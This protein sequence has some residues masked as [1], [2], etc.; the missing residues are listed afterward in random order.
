MKVT[1][2]FLDGEELEGESDAATLEKMGFP[3]TLSEGNSRT[4]WV[5]LAAIKYVVLHALTERSTSSDPRANRGLQ[6]VVFHFLDGDTVRSYK[7]DG[8]E[9]RGE[10]YA[11]QVWDRK[12]RSL[13]RVLVSM[14]SLK[15]VFYVDEWDARSTAEKR[16]NALNRRPGKQDNVPIAWVQDEALADVDPDIV[17]MA[18]VYQ[19][20]LALEPD[21]EITSDPILF[22]KAI[23]GS[24][25][26]ACSTRT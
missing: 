11:C 25:S 24:G 23:N 10:G 1:V 7:D 2:R 5:S 20:R 6:K 13:D 18:R 22:E 16:D 12:R 4:V 15:G 21:L 17:R 9:Q 19:R 26:S 14:H 3:L 8:F